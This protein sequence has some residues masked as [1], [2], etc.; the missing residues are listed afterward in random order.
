L[1]VWHSSATANSLSAVLSYT[2]HSP[3]STYDI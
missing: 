2:L 3:L 1:Y